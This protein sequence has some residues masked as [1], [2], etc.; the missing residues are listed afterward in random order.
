[1]NNQ[2]QPEIATHSEVLEML[3]EKA[4][5][6]STSAVIALERALGVDPEPNVVDDELDRVLDG[7]K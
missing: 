4:R 7:D 3:T 6:G 2:P 5:E 1:M